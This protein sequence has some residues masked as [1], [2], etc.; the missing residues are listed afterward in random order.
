MQWFRP[1]AEC[2]VGIDFRPEHDLNTVYRLEGFETDAKGASQKALAKRV[3]FKY[4]DTW[5]SATGQTENWNECCHV[6]HVIL[7]LLVEPA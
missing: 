3:A 1:L 2:D 5:H 7:T 4:G 6:E